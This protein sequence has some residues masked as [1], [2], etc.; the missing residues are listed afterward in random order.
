[1]YALAESAI[2]HVLGDATQRHLERMGALMERFNDVAAENPYS[3]FP[4]R[5]TAEELITPTEVNRRIC[6]PF[7]KYLCAIMDVDMAAGFVV[8]DAQTARELGFAAD[9][10]AYFAGWSDAKDIWYV[11]ERP[12]PARS[13][14]I[15]GLAETALGMAGAT[16]DEVT[17]FDLY[18]A[19]PAS[20]EAGMLAMDIGF[21]DPRPL[22]LTGGL[23][24]HGGAGNNYVSHAI[25]NALDR[26]RSGSDET[27]LVHGN[28]YF[29]T[30]H[31]VGVFQSRPPAEAPTPREDVQAMIDT[32]AT[33]VPLDGSAEGRGTIIAYTVNYE[34]SGEPGDAIVVCEIDRARTVAIGDEELRDAL[35]DEDLVGSTIE[36][37]AGNPR[38][39]VVA[40]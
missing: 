26:V 22:T 29:L 3:W 40:G 36:V 27:V 25:C 15:Q 35:I 28:G 19:F 37:T 34:R 5:R 10:V 21:E 31:A 33:P 2:T 38:N 16:I 24:Y 30:K 13:L 14:A 6:A 32:K 20:V 9:E 11:S 7:T 18:A 12:Q 1:M 39:R 8:T 17:S 4:T 23:A